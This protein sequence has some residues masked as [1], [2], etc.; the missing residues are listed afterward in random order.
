MCGI[1]GFFNCKDAPVKAVDALSEMRNRGIDG[2][3]IAFGKQ[4]RFAS[5]P[6]LLKQEKDSTAV[7][8]HVLHSVVGSVAQPL[9]GKGFLAA[10][11]EIYN[12]KELA[13]KHRIKARNDAGL[14]LKLI[15]K[16]KGVESVLKELD[17]VWAFAYWN[18]NRVVLSRDILGVKPLWYSLSNGFCFAS[19]KKALEKAGCLG[20]E[21]LDPRHVLEFDL[22]N[23]KAKFVKRK[24]FSAK[25]SAVNF[26]RSVESLKRLLQ[27]A[28]AKRVPEKKFGLLFSGG[29]DSVLLATVFKEMG[30]SFTCFFAYVKGFGE[31]ADLK[32]ARRAAKTLGLELEEIAVKKSDLPK[33]ISEVVLLIESSNP[34]K[35]GV[36][37]PLY[38]ACRKAKRRGI[39]VIF[40]G[41]GADELF[42]GYA[43][44]RESNNVQLDSINLL[45]QMH[46][47]DL[48][49]DDVLSMNN[50]LELRLAFLDLNVIKFAL[51][52]AKKFKLSS[53]QNKII[54]REAARSLGVPNEFASRKKKAAQYG[55]NFD[56]GIGKLA[57]KSGMRK[58][59]FLAGF[60]PK[61]NLKL[62]ALFSGGKDSCLALWIMQRQNY[63]VSC[64]V[65]V[66]PKNPDSYMYHQPNAR[67]V[68]LQSKALG[69]PLLKKT[70][71]GVKE[72][73][74]SALK[75]VL[76]D[77]KKKFGIQGVVSGALFSNYQRERIQ[78]ICLA[79]GLKLFSPLWHKKQGQEVRELVNN[80]FVFVMSKIAGYGLSK[81]WLGKPIGAKEIVELDRLNQRIGFNVAGEGGEYESLVLDAPN[82]SKR[83]VL[84][85]LATKMGNEFTGSLVIKKVS[86][87]GKRFNSGKD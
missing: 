72:K 63:D 69:I 55:S 18:G 51:P 39:K 52:L 12:W 20:I 26:E 4:A 49:R 53:K 2:A 64:L 17:G 87:K 50:S 79:L 75:S 40:S 33:L 41:L 78:K 54:L 44:F 86:L 27:D 35:V 82:F 5:F 57:K 47:N 43:R 8:G 19:E 6:K 59:E 56:K 73:E 28:V 84:G 29:I 81:E 16:S 58:A 11:C 21:E 34:V 32:F 71:K 77:A 31:P 30:Y 24:F 25:K 45:M 14:V 68:A 9:K 7:L 42:C 36:A 37:L 80:G 48:Y 74:L 13:A 85:K 10:N 60:A 15:E 3:G 66:F 1:A 76:L 62:A 46:E 83:I 70:T 65:S 23:G 38:A 67:V 61:K 22:K